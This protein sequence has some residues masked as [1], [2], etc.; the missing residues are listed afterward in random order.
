MRQS[1]ILQSVAE[2]GRDPG[3]GGNRQCAREAEISWVPAGSFC[4]GSCLQ[5]VSLRR[6]SLLRRLG[7]PFS[8]LRMA[9]APSYA[10]NPEFK[11]KKQVSWLDPRERGRRGKAVGQREDATLS[12]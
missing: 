5:N 6:G 9:F 7:R 11:Y 1:W 8:N 4:S 2:P 10:S 12:R 3:Q